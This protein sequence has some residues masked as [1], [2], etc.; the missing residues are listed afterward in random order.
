MERADDHRA[1]PVE[2]S[3]TAGSEL[4]QR[5]H[6]G[7]TDCAQRRGRRCEGSRHDGDRSVNEA[8]LVDQAWKYFREVQTKDTKYGPL[9]G[10]DDK[11]PTYLNKRIMDTIANRCVSSITILRSTIPI[12]NNWA[13][14]TRRRGK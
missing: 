6:D 5:C 14:N 13:L 3:G 4:G 1:L 7:H 12:L 10:P 9:I 8:G 11:P 2:H